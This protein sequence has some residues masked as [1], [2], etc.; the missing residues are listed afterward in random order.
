MA[1]RLL[2]RLSNAGRVIACSALLVSCA[3]IHNDPIKQ[4]LL[5]SSAPS[6]EVGAGVETYYDDT[7]VAGLLSGGGI[8]AAAFSMAFTGF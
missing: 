7:V 3:Q 2:Q 5:N 1:G 8:G 4:P 6:V